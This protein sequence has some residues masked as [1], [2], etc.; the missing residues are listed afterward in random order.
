MHITILRSKKSLPVDRI[1]PHASLQRAAIHT[2]LPDHESFFR[3]NSGRWLYNESD[4]KHCF[5]HLSRN[6]LLYTSNAELAARYVRFN[7]DALQRV[8]TN[9]AGATR[10]ISMVKS[11]E[12]ARYANIVNAC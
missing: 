10:C 1:S 5:T 2:Q 3:Y 11:N 9:A 4:R 7:V 12:G 8:A 6:L